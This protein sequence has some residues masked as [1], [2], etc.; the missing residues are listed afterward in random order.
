MNNKIV[1]IAVVAMLLILGA[2]FVSAT[3]A[4]SGDEVEEQESLGSGCGSGNCG[5]ACDGACGGSCGVPTCGC[6]G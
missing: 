4:D 5:S 1:G 6:G 2:V 3:L